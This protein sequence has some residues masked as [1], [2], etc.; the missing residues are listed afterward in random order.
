[1]LSTFSL[2]CGHSAAGPGETTDCDQDVLQHQAVIYDPVR[3]CSDTLQRLPVGC[4]GEPL[5]GGYYCLER[6]SDGVVVWATTVDELLFDTATWKRCA[7]DEST[8]PPPP[9]FASQCEQPPTS[10]C[11]LDQTK[12]QFAC[13]SSESEWDADCCKRRACTTRDDCSSNETCK[14]VASRVYWDCW[15]T[16]DGACDCGGISGGPDHLVCVP[17]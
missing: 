1:M 3:K 16:A 7:T 8:P 17:M 14:P 5:G 11:T 2:A 6:K 15:P 10:L 9:C 13:G 4:S 12:Q